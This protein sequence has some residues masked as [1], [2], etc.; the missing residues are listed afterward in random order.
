MLRAEGIPF[1]VVTTEN[2]ASL[3]KEHPHPFAD[4]CE[5]GDILWTLSRSDGDLLAAVWFRSG[6][7]TGGLGVNRQ[8]TLMRGPV[9]RDLVI[10]YG[11]KGAEAYVDLLTG[12]PVTLPQRAGAE[13]ASM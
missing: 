5:A 8:P 9:I 1:D 7:V 2:L 13:K 3:R 6:S 11:E 4:N 12:K 10:E